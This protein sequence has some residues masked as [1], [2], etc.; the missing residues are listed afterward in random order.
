[1][2][3]LYMEKLIESFPEKSLLFVYS[4]TSYDFPQLISQQLLLALRKLIKN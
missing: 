2:K 4:F 1:M 3:K